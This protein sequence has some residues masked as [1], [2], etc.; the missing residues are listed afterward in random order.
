MAQFITA[1]GEEIRST[2]MVF[3]SGPTEPDTKACGKTARLVERASSGTLTVI[4][5]KGSGS[6][7][8]QMVLAFTSIQMEQVTLDAG[9]TICRME[10]VRN[11]GLMGASISA[12]IKWAKKTERGN[13]GGQMEAT[14]TEHGLIIKLKVKA[15]TFGQ[16][17]DATLVSG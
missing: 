1:S 13:T 8:R 12:A 7:T 3:R 6:M 17:A 11:S 15:L 16:M 10:R 14:M 4:F 5:L 2:V 9:E